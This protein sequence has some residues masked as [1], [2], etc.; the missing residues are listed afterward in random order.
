[1]CSNLLKKLSHGKNQYNKYL[2]MYSMSDTAID[3]REEE[4]GKGMC[5]YIRKRNSLTS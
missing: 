3:I 2:N 1:M 5:V 4:E